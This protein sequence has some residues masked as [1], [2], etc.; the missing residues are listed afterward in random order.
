MFDHI[1]VNI[2]FKYMCILNLMKAAVDIYVILTSMQKQLLGMSPLPLTGTICCF[3]AC[4]RATP[5]CLEI[6][7]ES[8]F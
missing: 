3:A 4:K 5:D 6:M 8:S 1:D 2:N 7:C